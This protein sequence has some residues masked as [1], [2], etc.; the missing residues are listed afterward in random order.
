MAV[1]SLALDDERCIDICS[2]CVLSIDHCVFVIGGSRE[3]EESLLCDLTVSTRSSYAKM[4][5][6]MLSYL[7]DMFD[8]YGLIRTEDVNSTMLI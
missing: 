4:S 1:T 7:Q 6:P 3:G 8:E 2:V 5:T